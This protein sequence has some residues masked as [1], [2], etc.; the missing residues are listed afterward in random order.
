MIHIPEDRIGQHFTY[1]GETFVLLGIEDE[2]YVALSEFD[3]PENVS[4]SKYPA[5]AR[6][7]T[8]DD[9]PDM[10]FED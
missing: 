3:D 7:F 9:V 5:N 10:L 4:W 6:T 1:E 8:V 2:G